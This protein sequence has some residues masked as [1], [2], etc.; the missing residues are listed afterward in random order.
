[1]EKEKS[2][3]GEPTTSRKK[4]ASQSQKISPTLIPKAKRQK[5]KDSELG[6]RSDSAPEE[7]IELSPEPT[8]KLEKTH[9]LNIQSKKKGQ[10]ESVSAERI[11][12]GPTTSK[13][14]K[15]AQSKVPSPASSPKDQ[16]PQSK[17]RK[18]KKTDQQE[19]S[20][21]VPEAT[22]ELPQESVK[23]LEKTSEV[24]IVSPQEPVS[25]L[26]E[27]PKMTSGNKGKLKMKEGS[28]ETN[29]RAYTSI[30]QSGN[31]E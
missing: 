6:E 10:K 15:P 9:D 25:E 13:K 18:R 11:L 20:H 22:V 29:F 23:E 28:K 7:T 30:F 21:D 3:V 26:E 17:K 2:V 31:R 19:V 12:E 16:L 14:E 24:V 27:T 8:N 1:L 4:K 5:R